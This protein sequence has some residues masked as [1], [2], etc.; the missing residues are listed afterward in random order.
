MRKMRLQIVEGICQGHKVANDLAG[1]EGQSTLEGEACIPSLMSCCPL[2][3]FTVVLEIDGEGG[4]CFTSR[5]HAQF[6]HVS[7][8]GCCVQGLSFIQQVGK[9]PQF[10]P[11]CSWMSL[12]S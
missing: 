2:Q 10:S 7:K 3:N 12:S 5:S 9:Q 4:K 1:N 6:L 8:G 11:R